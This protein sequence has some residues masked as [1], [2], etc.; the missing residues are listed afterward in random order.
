MAAKINSLEL[1]QLRAKS[2]LMSAQKLINK[3]DYAS[4]IKKLQDAQ[5]L[6]QCAE[7]S[8]NIQ[9]ALNKAQQSLKQ[10]DQQKLP[11]NI[12]ERNGRPLKGLGCNKMFAG[13]VAYWH[14]FTEQHYCHCKDG[15]AWNR[16][17]SQC[18]NMQH[19]YQESNDYCKKEYMFSIPV[20]SSNEK[21]TCDYKA[22]QAWNKSKTAC[23]YTK[24]ITC[25]H[26]RKSTFIDKEMGYVCKYLEGKKWNFKI[27]RCITPP[28][29]NI[30][31]GRNSTPRWTMFRS[32]YSCYCKQGYFRSRNIGNCELRLGCRNKRI[33][34]RDPVSKKYVCMCPKRTAWNA[35]NRRCFTP[36][37]KSSFNCPNGGSPQ[38]MHS[39][40][41]YKCNCSKTEYWSYLHE[42][43][44]KSIL[45][46]KGQSTIYNTNTES[47]ECRCLGNKTY[48]KKRKLYVTPISCPHTSK[49]E[50]SS[51]KKIC[52]PL[53]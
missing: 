1:S 27:D 3:H 49:M 25:S 2:R 10:N 44:I 4:V 46:P 47:Y 14:P 12:W 20:W 6:S 30:T 26:G 24:N 40:E 7:L 52:L 8:A 28:P 37:P 43:C 38:L 39:L 11:A 45:C 29:V 23:I 50:W 31:C 5:V 48:D 9:T 15:E 19:A 36:P 17:G 35:R 53:Y 32:K 51:S 34:S 18:I 41:T 22:D 21:Y 13:S 42:R 16:I 33:T